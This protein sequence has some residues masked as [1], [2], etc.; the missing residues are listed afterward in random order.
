MLLDL[1]HTC[2]SWL[3][4]TPLWVGLSAV[5]LLLGGD[6]IP[7]SPLSLC[8]HVRRRLLATAGWDWELYLLM[9]SSLFC[10]TGLYFWP[11]EM[12]IPR[13]YLASDTMLGG[14]LGYLVTTSQVCMICL[15]TQPLLAG[16][17]AGVVVVV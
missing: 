2:F 11:K 12:K 10:G 3:S 8:W 6:R 7:G 4:L 17:L 16:C 14:V 13:P 15:P 1:F 9:W 5:L